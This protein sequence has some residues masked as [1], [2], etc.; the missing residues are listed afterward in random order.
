MKNELDGISLNKG[1]DLKA[2]FLFLGNYFLEIKKDLSTSVG[3]RGTRGESPY[4]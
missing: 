2:L 3:S 1:A 4:F